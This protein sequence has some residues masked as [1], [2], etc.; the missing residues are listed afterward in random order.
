[1]KS[2]KNF[3]SVRIVVKKII[4]ALVDITQKKCKGHFHCCWLVVK[5]IFFREI[6]TLFFRNNTLAIS[7]EKKNTNLFYIFLMLWNNWWAHSSLN[8]LLFLFIMIFYF[9]VWHYIF[10]LLFFEYFDTFLWPLH[11]THR[12]F[13]Y[14]YTLYIESINNCCWYMVYRE[15]FF[16][17]YFFMI[18]QLFFICLHFSSIH[19]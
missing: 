11:S 16:H 6:A 13:I 2:P 1:M 9:F 3:L 14:F 19:F 15:D 18:L 8:V 5:N 17:T 12:L 7:L 4:I 10:I